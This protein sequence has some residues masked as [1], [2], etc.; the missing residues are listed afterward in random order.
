MYLKYALKAGK[1]LIHCLVADIMLIRRKGR[2][3][4]APNLRAIMTYCIIVVVL[5]GIFI[6]SNSMSRPMIIKYISPILQD[7]GS[8]NGMKAVLSKRSVSW[9]QASVAG[10]VTVFFGIFSAATGIYLSAC[11]ATLTDAV[12]LTRD[13]SDQDNLTACIIAGA[14]LALAAYAGSTVSIY[15]AAAGW[16]YSGASGTASKRGG[17]LP[18][19]GAFMHHLVGSVYAERTGS[20]PTE[21]VELIS[22][23]APTHFPN[24]WSSSR[25]FSNHSGSLEHIGYT[26]SF[27]STHYNHTVVTDAFGYQDAV[28]T[29]GNF[30]G[31][32]Y[33]PSSNLLNSTNS[34]LTK[35][36]STGFWMSYTGWDGNTGYEE[37]L[38]EWQEYSNMAQELQYGDLEGI[39]EQTQSCT[40]SYY[41]YASK[42]KFCIGMGFSSD[43]GIDDA[44]VGESYIEAYGGLDG[45][46]EEG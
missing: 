43:R 23:H 22:Q 31:S 24:V 16:F 27:N 9:K 8:R 45:E 6:L 3:I 40:N 36:D 38:L 28:V 14:A 26:F 15:G 33:T 41:C 21:L 30:D 29:L 7:D 17:I 39:V 25:L 19:D 10:A 34:V 13:T 44:E 1:I 18:K 5:G 37:D 20:H 2:G 35:R 42:D 11:S 32:S 46:C 12:H 4:R